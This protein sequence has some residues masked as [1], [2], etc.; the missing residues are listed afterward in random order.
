MVA[1]I[2]FDAAEYGRGAGGAVVILRAAIFDS[3]AGRVFGKALRLNLVP[4]PA[5][6]ATAA[7]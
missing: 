2:D 7:G 1:S 6:P 5:R 4:A 3:R